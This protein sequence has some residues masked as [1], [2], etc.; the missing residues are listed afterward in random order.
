M[1]AQAPISLKEALAVRSKA[2]RDF[3]AQT[4]TG[5]IALFAFIG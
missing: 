4:T 1:A 2:P 3:L 5:R